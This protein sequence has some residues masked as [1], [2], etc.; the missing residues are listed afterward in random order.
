VKG[1]KGVSFIGSM[2]GRS[3]GISS[4]RRAWELSEEGKS[5]DKLALQKR[6][7]VG[8]LSSFKLPSFG[9]NVKP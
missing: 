6:L 5:K 3:A 4:E 1:K 2:W 8:R 7:L 9:F